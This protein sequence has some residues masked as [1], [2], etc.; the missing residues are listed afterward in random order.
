MS[1]EVNKVADV[2]VI[3]PAYQARATI[4]RALASVAG[5]TR[6]PR[7]VVVVD[8]GSDDGTLEAVEAMAGQM[9]G[10]PLSVESQDNQGAG[11]ARNRALNKATSTYIA[12]LDADD[13]WMAEKIE[14]SMAALSETSH[15]LA[16]HDFIRVE[17]DG[18]EQAIECARRF[19]QARNPFAGLFR[20]GFIGTSTV[21]ARR[22]AVQAVG[23]FDESL[24]TA[25][26]FDLWLKMLAAKG[27][28]FTI[29]P[30][31]L[32][33]YYVTCGSITSFTARRLACSLMIARR[34]APGLLNLWL[35]IVAI[36]YEAITA[37]RL[38]GQFFQILYKTFLLPWNL[39]TETLAFRSVIATSLAQPRWVVMAIW[40]WVIGAY[41]AYVYRFQDL[42]LA[43]VN[44]LK[45]L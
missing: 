15:V 18:T 4:G 38:G 40:A 9:N 42:L 20:Q 45:Q 32:T 21:V 29:F 39:L 22:D 3:I 30:E 23:G 14:R 37:Y 2:S 43:A 10:I 44:M 11:S 1:L 31:A 34:H 33:R 36:H 41:S 35:R 27:T 17:T 6:K 8:D 24:E 13:E 5:Q 7:E 28:T 26:D 12:F 25:Q 16:G 19:H